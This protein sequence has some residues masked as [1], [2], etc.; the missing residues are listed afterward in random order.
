[1]TR[2]R[3]A[4]T[5]SDD[6]KIAAA[7]KKLVKIGLD[8]KE[9]MP[10]LLEKYGVLAYDF[11]N[12]AL[13]EPGRLCNRTGERFQPSKKLI[14][15][16][17]NDEI[18]DTALAKAVNR[19][20]AEVKLKAGL[21]KAEQE[22]AAQDASPEIKEVQAEAKAKEEKVEGRVD[23]KM[24][25]VPVREEKKDD[26]FKSYLPIEKTTTFT[27]DW[28]QNTVPSNTP[29]DA[30]AHASDGENSPSMIL[31]PQYDENSPQGQARKKAQE[32]VREMKEQNGGGKIS[33]AE[34]R[35][36]GVLPSDLGEVITKDRIGEV[37]GGSKEMEA[38]ARCA[39]ATDRKMPGQGRCG[40]AA[41]VTLRD[42]VGVNI[43]A[44]MDPSNTTYYRNG[45]K[46]ERTPYT[47]TNYTDSLSRNPEFVSLEFDYKA[48]EGISF[49]KDIHAKGTGLG[50]EGVRNSTQPAGHLAF[51]G[52]DGQWHADAT[53]SRAWLSNGAARRY[54]D[55]K[56]G[57]GKVSVI[58]HNSA[59]V[60]DQV[61]ED[62]LYQKY[63]REAEFEKI[64]VVNNV[65]SN[66]NGGR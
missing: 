9:V 22:R 14:L 24:A 19:K 56:T 50:Y 40:A 2:R 62:A 25:Q 53:N 46:V 43:K 55:S 20:P 26:D 58:F 39:V 66:G 30:A 1:M 6:A 17:A 32:K 4:Q 5:M 35:A 34:L 51:L 28:R 13:Q 27:P 16:Y 29:T 23:E 45:N 59:Q 54:S 38:I 21:Y 37:Y 7:R 49:L 41:N 60:S 11:V 47:A 61:A 65:L 3:T 63:L 42:S 10:K 33:F 31:D 15:H 36:S 18:S 48:K 64:N 44:Y 57:E 52:S 8:E 12:N